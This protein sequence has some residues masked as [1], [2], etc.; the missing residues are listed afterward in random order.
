MDWGQ[1]G[2]YAED[3]YFDANVPNTS[4]AF[5]SFKDD[6]VKTDTYFAQRYDPLKAV[7][8]DCSEY[9]KL[10]FQTRKTTL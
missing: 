10:L 9:M 5:I 4:V 8:V 2:D 6:A 7:K 3:C 1:V